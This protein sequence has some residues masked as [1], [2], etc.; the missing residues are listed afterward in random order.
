MISI[1]KLKSDILP[2]LQSACKQQQSSLHVTGKYAVFFVNGQEQF[3]KD[4]TIELLIISDNFDTS[5]FYEFITQYITINSEIESSNKKYSF[6]SNDY[7]FDISILK[8]FPDNCSINSKNLFINLENNTIYDPNDIFTK[9]TKDI[10]TVKSNLSFKEWSIEHLIEIITEISL[11]DNCELSIENLENIRKKDIYDYYSITSQ[12]LIENILLSFKPGYGLNFIINNIP[13]GKDWVFNQLI[14]FVTKNNIFLNEDENITKI[15][16]NDRLELID[17]Y[18]NFFLSEKTN[19]ESTKEKTDRLLTTMRLLFNSPSIDLPLPYI[20]KLSNDKA[21]NVSLFSEEECLYGPCLECNPSDCSPQCCCCHSIDIVS[22]ATIRCHKKAILSCNADGTGYDNGEEATF[23]N[24]ESCQ[25]ACETILGIREDLE[26]EGCQNFTSIGASEGWWTIPATNWPCDCSCARELNNQCDLTCI[27]CRNMYCNSVAT[28]TGNDCNYRISL[29][30]GDDCCGPQNGEEVIF[31]IHASQALTDGGLP[32][33]GVNIK[34]ITQEFASRINNVNNNTRFGLVTFGDFHESSDDFQSRYISNLTTYEDFLNLIPETLN[35]GDLEDS[36]APSPWYAGI[37]ALIETNWTT[38]SNKRVIFVGGNAANY[39]FDLDPVP[40]LCNLYEDIFGIGKCFNSYVRISQI[41]NIKFGLVSHNTTNLITNSQ[42]DTITSVLGEIGSCTN[43]YSYLEE[44]GDPNSFFLPEGYYCVESLTGFSSSCDCI[45]TTPIPIRKDSPECKCCKDGV[46]NPCIDDPL[47]SECING[48]PESCFEIPILKCLPGEECNCSLPTALNVCGNTIVIEPIFQNMVCCSDLGFG[49]S[50]DDDTGGGDDNNPVECCGAQCHDI[51]AMYQQ[52]SNID[53]IIDFVWLDCWTK[54]AGIDQSST[55]NCTDA[56]CPDPSNIDSDNY[57]CELRDPGSSEP[58]CSCLIENQTDCCNCCIKFLDQ[59]GQ[60]TITY[61]RQD[62]SQQVRS[63]VLDCVISPPEIPPWNPPNSSCRIDA[64]IVGE[65]NLDNTEINDQCENKHIGCTSVKHP[66]TVVLNNGIGLVAYES[67]KDTSVI[68]IQ[69]FNTSVGNKLLPNRE[70]NF[71]RLE[72]QSKWENGIAKIYSYDPIPDH[73]LSASSSPSDDSTWKDII[74]FRNGPLEKQIFPITS[75]GNNETG[76]YISFYVGLSPKLSNNF[77]SIDDVYDI[78]YFIADAEDSGVIGDSYD[79]TTDGAN[80]NILNRSVVD[81]AL[82]LSPHIFNG[83]RAPVAYPNIACAYNYSQSNENSQFVYLVYQALEDNKWN[84]YFRQI[85]LSE[86]E[87]ET[88]IENAVEEYQYKTIQELNITN[89]VY[90]IVCTNDSCLESGSN[91]LL[92]RTVVFEI[93]TEDGRELLNI[94]LNGDWP[95][96]C[97]GHSSSEFPKNKVF[98]QFVHYITADRCVDYSKFNDLFYNWIVGQEFSVPAVNLSPEELF[99]TIKINND[100]SVEIGEFSPPISA[101]GASILSSSVVAIW[102]QNISESNWSVIYGDSFSTLKN[103]KGLDVSEPILLTNNDVGHCTRPKIKINYNNDI[104]VVYESTEF[105]SNQIKI[106]GTSIP[107]S[108]LPVGVFRPK[109]LDASLNY[110]ISSFDFSYSYDITSPTDGLNQLPDM[111]IDLNDVVHI[112]WQSNRDQRWEIYYANS[113]NQFQPIRI[114]DHIGKSLNPSIDGDNKGNLFVC[115]HD[116]RFGQ[117]YEIMMAYHKGT[118]ILPLFQQDPYLASIRNDGYN[119]Y[120]DEISLSITNDT[121][122]VICINNIIVDFYSD[123]TLTNFEFSVNQNTYPFAFNIPGSENDS[124]EQIFE[125]FLSGWTEDPYD[126]AIISPEFD[127]ALIN[128][129]IS[130]FVIDFSKYDSNDPPIEL[131]FRGSNIAN[132]PISDAQ[133]SDWIP[134][135][136]NGVYYYNS[137]NIQNTSGRYKQVKIKFNYSSNIPTMNRLEITSESLHR[138]CLS[139][140]QNVV[141][142]LDLTPDIRIDSLGLLTQEIPLSVDIESNKSYFIKIRCFDDNGLSI[143]MPNQKA[144]VSCESCNKNQSVWD[145]ESCSLKFKITNTSSEFNY[146]NF[147]VNIYSDSEKTNKIK[148]F[149]LTYN[150]ID[151][152]SVT[153]NNDKANL[154][155]EERGLKI[156]GN[157]SSTILVWPELSQSAGLICGIKYFVEI[158]YCSS[159]NSSDFTCVDFNQSI[160][161]S[162]ICNCNSVRWSVFESQN[163]DILTKYRWFSSAYGKSDTRITETVNSYNIKPVVKI[164]SDLNGIILYQTNRGEPDN[165]DQ[166]NFKIY[167]S[168]FLGLPNADMFSSGAESIISDF[169]SIL[170]KSDIPICESSDLTKLGCF[171]D[172]HEKINP[173]L[174]GE[175]VSFA[176]DQYDNLFLAAEKPLPDNQCNEFNKNNQRYIVVHTCGSDSISLLPNDSNDGAPEIC[177][178]ELI[179]NKTFFDTN[180]DKNIQIVARVLSENVDYSITQNNIPMSVVSTCSVKIEIRSTSDTLSVRLKNSDQK[181]FSKWIKE[182]I[183]EDTFIV[184]WKLSNNSGIKL[185]EFQCAT[186]N[187]ISNSGFLYIFANYKKIDY[188]INLYKPTKDTPYPPDAVLLNDENIWLDENILPTFTGNY[189]ASLRNPFSENDI[190]LIPIADYVFVEIVPSK[191]YMKQF[192][193]IPD[194]EKATGLSNI[195]PKFDFI[196]QG[197][198]SYYGLATIW[199]RNNKGEEVFR[200][201]II[202]NKEDNTNFQDGLAEII[203]YFKNDCSLDSE[204]SNQVQSVSYNKDSFNLIK[205]KINA[206]SSENQIENSG[207]LLYKIKIR[208]NEDPYFVFGDPDYR[209][210]D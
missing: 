105:G 92:K 4:N 27:T 155:W 143:D 81:E 19:P 202:L 10:F 6:W 50:C 70:L 80:F 122:N 138:I 137:F 67:Q 178:S 182:K 15:F 49:C 191:E 198:Q 116:D 204:T 209:I 120:I 88:Q 154:I 83:E 194:I 98:A 162:W 37:R 46:T 205:E 121:N 171:N 40:D 187:G 207:E 181:S 130:K 125:E 62:I 127:T 42:L 126:I 39:Q 206:L 142:Y 199:A 13:N 96:L 149:T 72:N 140:N 129:Y 23:E 51:C 79:S 28:V 197:K 118:R 59:S 101:S 139:P 22:A 77:A 32:R 25:T 91:F 85:R 14:N 76:N 38:N 117:G 44:S 35:Q 180:L 55:P 82:L 144:S 159:A 36:P 31:V 109:N 124:T 133:W 52:N 75:A 150:N 9:L 161:F 90:R 188:S 84:V 170:Y 99:D 107:Y 128:S 102:Y 5:K 169:N 54:K 131:S 45:N 183:N 113:I 158:E 20:N 192:N 24:C 66:S 100:S 147:R 108:S 190:I 166:N 74:A 132:D 160:S 164:R 151:L 33:T 3:I 195:E 63:I 136:D 114:T 175:N 152:D 73:L 18:N 165:L 87:K 17:L 185:I 135:S 94:G 179:L 93:L 16:S 110:F 69:Q 86:Y 176:L 95:S 53:D 8:N 111:F 153:V 145:F 193:D 112:V 11:F 196:H 48:L 167:S 104:F 30:P 43:F 12:E 41:N 97:P 201:S 26:G 148:N 29:T 119:H 7:I 115:W 89:L 203:P 65:P 2:I 58:C 174:H 172:K 78:K 141:G 184:D 21:N 189:V 168:V 61:C 208:P 173:T 163:E 123:R 64:C 177:N 34:A 71:G 68:K 146:Y 156:D 56:C 200:G 157:I 134:I 47:D 57:P 1:Y 60:P 103:F 186:V 210:H 106:I